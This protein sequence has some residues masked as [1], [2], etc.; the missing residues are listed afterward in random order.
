[1]LVAGMNRTMFSPKIC[2]RYMEEVVW[3][4]LQDG[5]AVEQGDPKIG[6]VGEWGLC[7]AMFLCIPLSWYLRNSM[8]FCI[9][10]ALSFVD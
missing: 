2:I 10:Q 9:K 5:M 7:A 3:P 8:D 1:M 6:R 4:G